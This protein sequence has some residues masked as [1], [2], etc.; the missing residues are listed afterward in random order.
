VW[1]TKYISVGSLTAAATCP[2]WI[3]LFYRSDVS[4]SMLMTASSLIPIL[5][6]YTHRA[7]I[8][9]LRLGKEPKITDKSKR[10]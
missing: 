8:G 4:F 1:R 9:R 7:N 6:I 3:W 10:I 5:M 2:F